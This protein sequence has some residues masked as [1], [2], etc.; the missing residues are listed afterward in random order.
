MRNA[1][2][3]EIHSHSTA[4]DGEYTPEQLAALMDDAGVDLWALTD[5][6]TV[7]GC[8]E[9]QRAAEAHALS[10]VPG[11][12]ISA[13]L[14]GESIHVLG[15]GFRLDSPIL[16]TYG[17]ELVQARHDRM[18]QMVERMCEL[19]YQVS[20]DDVLQIADGGNL[21]RPHLAKAL[22]KRGHV[23]S[24][25]KAF[26]RWL[27]NDGP[28]YV[29]MSRPAVEDAIE[30]IIDLGGMVVLAH[31]ARYRD[32]SEH[33]ARWKTIGLW[34]LEV[35]HPSHNTQEE[36]QLIRQAEDVGLGKTASNDWHGHKPGERQRLGQVN[37]PD[38]WRQPFLDELADTASL[39]S[40]Q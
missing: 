30:M 23:D 3:L 27:A 17:D 21:C 32:V 33:L 2:T 8:R 38:E 16:S 36:S 39:R 15:Y 9:A 18:T 20:M 7:E 31:P 19:G 28:G 22:V 1:K 14:K 26:D 34:G 37:F 10:F 35:R 24:I 12:E 5:H 40:T 4:S 29:G 13:E 11:I 6:D 25:Q